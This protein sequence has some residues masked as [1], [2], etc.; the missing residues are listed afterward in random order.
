[1]KRREFIA[2]LGSA[3]AWPAVV[4]AQQAAKTYRMGYLSGGTELGDRE[5]LAGFV[6]GM[7]ALG[8]TEGQNLVIASRYADGRFERLPTLVR[9]LLSLNPEVIVVVTTPGNLAAKAATATVPIVMVG[10]ADP[11]GV[12]LIQ[13]LARPGGNITGITNIVAELTG[14]RLDILK[15]IVPMASKVAVLINPDDPNAPFQM[16]YAEAA[17]RNLA[18]ELQPV[19]EIRGANDLEGVFEA[20]AR[21]RVDAAL[22]MVD[23]LE[24]VLSKQTAVLALKHRLPVVYPFR[25]SVENGGLVSYGTDLTDQFRQAG[26]L[27]HKILGGAKPADLPVEQPIKFE[28]AINLKTAKALGLT[29]PET[30]LATADELIQ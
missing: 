27:V 4:R 7:R 2:G 14:K 11:L 9:E 23:P 3:A 6:R 1:M 15:Q 30:L 26:T 17:A 10:V 13:S 12:G 25:P 19:L 29:I 18:I 20:A 16:R 22:R 21:A 5:R 24:S 8:Y 28:L